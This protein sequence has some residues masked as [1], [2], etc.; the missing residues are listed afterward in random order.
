MHPPTFPLFDRKT[1][2]NT[3]NSR[4]FFDE[5]S[6][7]DAFDE[8]QDD[9]RLIMDGIY[10]YSAYWDNRFHSGSFVRIIAGA[11]IGNA[12]L[13]NHKCLLLFMAIVG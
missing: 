12:T 5:V 6:G 3:F 7:I 11:K 4:T 9:W 10:T 13:K 1:K 8:D 2:D